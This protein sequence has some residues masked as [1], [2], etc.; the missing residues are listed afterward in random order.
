M[1]KQFKLLL[2]SLLFTVISIHINAQA[3]SQ[4]ASIIDLNHGFPNFSNILEDAVN[5]GTSTE[6]KGTG[7]GPSSIKYEYMITDRIGLGAEFNYANSTVSYRDI[8]SNGN[9]YNYEVS[10]PRFRIMPKF[11]FHFGT[12]DIAD[13]YASVAAGYSSFSFNT[14]TNDPD[15][16]AEDEI[17]I[18]PTNI[19][20]RLALG[21]RVFITD[22]VGLGMEIGL[23]GGA[24]I[25][26]GLAFKIN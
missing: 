6:I 11:N 8:G 9:T 12:S 3:V 4:G 21:T 20:F 22:N 2:F 13:F 26:G 16:I 14:K 1:M 24:L 25:A 7:F 19:A 18:N 5:T 15:Y 23:G 10:I 17:D